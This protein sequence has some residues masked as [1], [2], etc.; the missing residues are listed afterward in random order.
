VYSRRSATTRMECR[1]SVCIITRCVRSLLPLFLQS[2]TITRQILCLQHHKEVKAKKQKAASLALLC[3]TWEPRTPW[4]DTR[5]A[6]RV[7]N[8]ADADG[9]A[10]RHN[11]CMS[12]DNAPQESPA[13]APAARILRKAASPLLPNK[14]PEQPTSKRSR[15]IAGYRHPSAGKSS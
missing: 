1:C 6:A 13:A 4:P 12:A 2:I 7:H 15:R 11:G 3:R 14:S 5:Q 9:K 10:C 8:E